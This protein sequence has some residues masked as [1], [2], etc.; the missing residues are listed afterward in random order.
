MKEAHNN[1]NSLFILKQV[2]R[3]ITHRK[4]SFLPMQLKDTIRVEYLSGQFYLSRQGPLENII[5]VY[6]TPI[7]FKLLML[8]LEL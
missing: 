6:T 3:I 7:F 2:K 5:W 1:K 4:V 8:V